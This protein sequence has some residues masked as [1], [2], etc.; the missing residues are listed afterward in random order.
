MD[1]SDGFVVDNDSEQPE[2]EP[3]VDVES[4][5]IGNTPQIADENEH[6]ENSNHSEDGD[7][8]QGDEEEDLEDYLKKLEN[9]A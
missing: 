7:D 1:K 3:E 6:A 4:P 2:E 8:D 9:E 5:D